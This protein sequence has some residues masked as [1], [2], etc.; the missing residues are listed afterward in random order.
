VVAAMHAYQQIGHDCDFEKY[1][2]AAHKLL[3]PRP[4]IHVFVLQG[5]DVL[6]ADGALLRSEMALISALAIR[7]SMRCSRCQHRTWVDTIL[8]LKEHVTW[9]GSALTVI[10]LPM[11]HD[12]TV[13]VWPSKRREQS[14]CTLASVVSRGVVPL[15]GTSASSEVESRGGRTLCMSSLIAAFVWKVSLFPYRSGTFVGKSEMA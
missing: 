4:Q 15:L 8:S 10:D 6:F 9:W 14:V 13:D 5:L 7:S 12:G 3:N 2:G 11:R 1:N